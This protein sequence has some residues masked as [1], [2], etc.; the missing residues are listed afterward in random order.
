LIVVFEDLHLILLSLLRLFHDVVP[1]AGG[2]T[3]DLLF[4]RIILFCV[5]LNWALFIITVFLG[6]LLRRFLFLLKLHLL[7]LINDIFGNK[8]SVKLSL[9]IPHLFRR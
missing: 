3:V 4:G 7:K 1:L 5:N 6:N 2:Q 8:R 9:F